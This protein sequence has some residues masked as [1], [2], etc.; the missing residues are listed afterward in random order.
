MDD[1]D[2]KGI[3]RHCFKVAIES[4]LTGSDSPQIFVM[5][6]DRLGEF[7]STAIISE[8]AREVIWEMVNSFEFSEMHNPAPQSMMYQALLLQAEFDDFHQKNIPF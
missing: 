4:S 7:F 3:K 1:K 8:E 6:C 5:D 2:V